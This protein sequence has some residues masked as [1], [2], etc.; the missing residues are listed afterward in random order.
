MVSGHQRSTFIP[1]LPSSRRVG[2]SEPRG[3]VLL[4]ANS[5]RSRKWASA[6]LQV[7]EQGRAQGSCYARDG[8][9]SRTAARRR[10][11]T[12]QRRRRQQQQLGLGQRWRR[13]RSGSLRGRGDPRVAL[14]PSRQV[15][16][17]SESESERFEHPEPA[18]PQISSAQTSLT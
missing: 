3:E 13:W 8:A 11:G 6:R 16:E 17:V 1:S 10:P 5:Q 14:R 9:L 7:H 2:R 18:N 4:I 12:Q 15:H